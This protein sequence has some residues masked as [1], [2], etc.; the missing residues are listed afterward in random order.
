MEEIKTCEIC[1]FQTVNGRVMSNH[2]RWKHITD[3]T[4]NEYKQFQLKVGSVRKVNRITKTCICE[5]CGNTFEQ[6]HSQRE[7]D[8][9][10][11]VRRFC[12]ISCSNS[13]GKRTDEF[14]NHLRELF[15]KN[16]N[17][18][19][20]CPVCGKK[21]LTNKKTFCSSKCAHEAQKNNNLDD[22]KVYRRRCAFTFALN[23]F[24]NEFDFKLVE[25]YGWYAASNSKNPNIDGVS[26]DHMLSV[27]YGFIHK[28]D[29]KIISHPAN[30][31]LVRQ[32]E[33]AS[34]NSDCS[35][36]YEQLLERIK[37][38][39]DKYGKYYP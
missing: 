20:T 14:K 10:K 32:N 30:C 18:E 29:P 19:V 35:I 9:G 27:K 5:K 8:T 33:N 4:S 16:E 25:K 38:W 2:K 24:P 28:I 15:S 11:N 12:C 21:F 13:R 39:E 6:T 17:V 34:K 3:R 22:L 37:T 36:T 7:W 23:Q 31:M 26:R 1:G